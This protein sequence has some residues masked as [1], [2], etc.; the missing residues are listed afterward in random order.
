LFSQHATLSET[1]IYQRHLLEFLIEKSRTKT[2][3]L[4]EIE[5]AMKFFGSYVDVLLSKSLI[6]IDDSETYKEVL[7]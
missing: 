2:I 1:Q 6:S 7:K 4:V 3:E 5:N